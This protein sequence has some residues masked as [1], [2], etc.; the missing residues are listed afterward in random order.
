MLSS[1]VWTRASGKL[2]M[3]RRASAAAC[4]LFDTRL[5]KFHRISHHNLKFSP[6]VQV[7]DNTDRFC[8]RSFS[9]ASAAKDEFHDDS[10]F[11][12]N[13][14]NVAIVAHVD[15][16]KTTIVDNLLRCATQSIS[17]SSN[18]DD[19][20][21]DLVMDCGDL[22]RERGITIKSKV[23]RLD[24]QKSG[25]DG[26]FTINVV[27]T[28][29]H[30]DFAGE[31][32]RIISMIDGVCLVVDAAEGAMAQTKYVLS[33][34]LRAGL[35]PIVIL[36][37]CDKDEAWARIE[38]GEVE[39]ELFD[40]FDGLGANDE[41]MDY[42]TIYSSG[43]AGWATADIDIAR[44]IVEGKRKPDGMTSMTALL[45]S[46]LENIKPPQVASLRGINDSSCEPFALAAT[47]VGF[48]NFLGRLC[49]GRI[50]SG[51]IQKGDV[52][53]LIPRNTPK[54][55]VSSMNLQ[56]STITGIFVN[57]GVSRIP[58]EP[59]IAKAGDIVTLAGVPDV[60][61]VGDS[62]TLLSN[63]LEAPIE[64]PP[65]NPPTISM[66]IGANTSP[67]AGKEGTIVASSRVRE[68]LHHEV[69]N[70]VTL[71]ITKSETDAERSVVHARGELQ[72]GILIEE[73]RREGYEMTVSP[74]K[75]ITT[76][77]PETGKI[78]EPF[79]EV[80][81]DVE[82][83]FSGTAINALTGSRKGVL[84][85]M[86]DSAD[87]KT[88]LTF[89]VPSRGLLGFNNEIST[90]TRG[91]AVVNHLFLENR[92][93]AGHVGG[94]YKGKL[95]SNDSGKANI[96]SLANIANRGV[97]FIDPGDIVYG[98]MVIGENSK[99]GDLEVNPVRAKETSNVRSAGKEEKA[100]VPPSKKMTIEEFI[101]YMND[102]E[103]LEVTPLSVR[104]RK[105]ELDPGIREREA[106][107]RKKQMAAI[108]DK[109]R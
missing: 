24:Y 69:D 21:G 25:H 103:V 23:T 36:N 41:Q 102:D 77:C 53:A 50:Y 54:E 2:S 46:I 67:L 86:S 52:V 62:I 20:R 38:D 90:L 40:V 26:L 37:K 27:D 17:E 48:D 35:K 100:Y 108:A 18:N 11:I 55:Q 4:G 107:K 42:I 85:N 109:K 66:E 101:G 96:Y 59:P 74:P 3:G 58:L 14:R 94:E 22:E 83:E 28:P 95:V 105:S 61:N 72:L 70:N 80:I 44:E 5:S 31:V 89:E 32:D 91:T 73:M 6:I 75:I 81:I 65:I 57:R 82:S 64:T 87:G 76:V 9:V 30:S 56:S 45:D 12:Q 79:E 93:Y 68:R 13:I 97:L 63:P 39:T 104:L 43:K 1:R 78:L 19:S 60:M 34:A 15:H 106:R 88:R 29:G 7:I 47:T 8:I 99:T 92:E 10:R 16:G 71:A 51:E 33:R 98:G 84:L 49:T